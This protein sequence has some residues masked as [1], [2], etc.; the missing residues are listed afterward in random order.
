LTR[1]Q[2]A[3][4][5]SD[6]ANAAN[7][8]RGPLLNWIER[9]VRDEAEA[10][11]VYQE[12]IEHFLETYEVGTVIEQVSA[13]LYRVAQNKIIDR[14]RKKKHELAYEEMMLLLPEAESLDESERAYIREEIA[15]A[16]ELLPEEQRHVFVMH[17]LEGKSFA[18]ISKET[19]ISVNT[20]LSRKR[21]AIL[22]LR[23]HLKE[24]YDEL[25]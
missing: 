8:Y 25:E 5:Q 3:K 4:R 2:K 20:L 24:V 16:I 12:V 6:A 18:E 19:G 13:W 11:D 9:K 1:K 10:E 21:Y 15:E 14:F 22:F 7:K 23:E 17:E